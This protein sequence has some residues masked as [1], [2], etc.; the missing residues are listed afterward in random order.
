M[1]LLPTNLASL[2]AITDP[3]DSGG[4]FALR[5]IHL[6]VHGDNTYT[7]EATDARFALRVT[8]PCVADAADYPTA[9]VAGLETAPNGHTDALVPAGAWKK[10]FS[11]AGKLTRKARDGAVVK[12]VA[13][14]IGSD[15]TTLGATDGV[16]GTCEMSENVVG[17]FPPLADIVDSANKATE[18]TVSVDARKLAELLRAMADVL[19]D[20]DDTNQVEIRLAGKGK[21]VA[22]EAKRADGTRIAGLLMPLA[23]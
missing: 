6:R 1:H 17:R 2:A 23:D 16:T 19:A 7:A 14:K 13:V 9:R 15:V 20:A 21:P 5:T 3:K 10:A 11:A 12:A 22:L 18:A 4:R 8:G